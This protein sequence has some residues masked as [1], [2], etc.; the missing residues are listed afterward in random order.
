MTDSMLAGLDIGTSK[1]TCVVAE[2]DDDGELVISSTEALSLS[3]VPEE[4]VVAGAGAIGLELGS[5]W[6]RLGSRVTVVEL[7]G[8]VLPGWDRRLSRSLQRSL[9][10]QGLRFMFRSRVTGA[11]KTREGLAVRVEREES[12]EK[13]TLPADRV[14]VAVGRKPRHREAGIEDAGVETDRGGFIRV[15]RDYRAAGGEVYAVGDVIGGPMLAHKAQDEGIACVERMSG[16]PGRVRYDTVPNVIYTAPEAASVGATEEQLLKEGTAFRRGSFPFKANGR[17]LAMGSTEGTARVL[18][19]Q[20]TG[21][22]LGV[23]VVGPQASTLIAEAVAV[24]EYGG[25]AEDIA[26]IVHAHPTLP[27]AVRE[28]ALD[29]EGRAIHAVS[30]TRTGPGPGNRAHHEEDVP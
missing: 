6:A 18:A 9:R 3:T 14:L 25:S 22:V 12:G 20:K 30:R 21:K 5:V 27:E 26:R 16:I 11:E 1:V 23:H 24:M 29:A 28:A 19:H 17:A 10:E 15:D 8:T 2:L 13:A 7:T 4:L